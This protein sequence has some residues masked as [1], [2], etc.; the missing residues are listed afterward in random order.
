MTETM[1]VTVGCRFPKR[2]FSFMLWIAKGLGKFSSSLG[3]WLIRKLPQWHPMLVRFGNG[4]W[5]R[6]EWEVEELK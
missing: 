5:Q 2:R 3:I 4:S 6:L 1:T